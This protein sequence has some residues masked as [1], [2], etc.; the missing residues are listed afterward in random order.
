MKKSLG[1]IT[2]VGITLLL[3]FGCSKP[4]EPEYLAFENLQIR[5]VGISESIVG[6]DLKYYNPNGFNLQLK[7]ADLD[8]YI[9]DRFVGHSVLDTLIEIPAKDTFYVPISFSLNLG[10]LFKNALQLLLNPEVKLRIEGK[11]RVGKSGFYRNV[12]VSYEGKERIDVLMKDSSF[13]KLLK[14]F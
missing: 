11:A 4:K 14:D 10:D 1:I 7:K 5:K 9:N 3:S 12:P 13:Q 6:A 2:L 8:L